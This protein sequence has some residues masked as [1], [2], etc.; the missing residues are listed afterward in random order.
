MEKIKNGAADQAVVGAGGLL[1]T[2]SM[3]IGLDSAH[4]RI[5]MVQALLDLG[6]ILLDLGH[7]LL[8]LADLVRHVIEPC[9][10]H[11]GQVVNGCVVCHL[12]SSI[13]GVR[14]VSMVDM[15][16]GVWRWAVERTL[17]W[18]STCRGFLVRDEKKA[19]HF[20]VRVF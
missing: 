8:G 4:S 5:E 3:D 16:R 18:L 15:H 7:I 13:A 20:D 12:S 17:A 14:G 2:Q 6:H 11:A 10:N 9:V 1:S 19:I